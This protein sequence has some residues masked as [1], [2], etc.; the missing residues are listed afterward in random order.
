MTNAEIRAELSQSMLGA[1]TAIELIA[2]GLRGRIEP[3]AFAGIEMV[4]IRRA[5]A[6]AH[7]VAEELSRIALGIREQRR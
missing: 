6:A 3:A 5:F 1:S 7:N 2:E 4:E